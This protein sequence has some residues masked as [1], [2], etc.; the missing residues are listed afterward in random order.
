MAKRLLDIVFSALAI[1]I[2]SPVFLIATVGILISSEGP[3][4]YKARRVG[5]NG[6]I[7]TMY[8]FRSMLVEHPCK[9]VITGV[10]DSRVYPFGSFLRKSKIDELPQLFN[11]LAGH[12]S[13]VGP[14]PE[15]PKIVE[16]HF[17]P[18]QRETL[19]VL[20]GLTG[21]GSIF[22]YTQAKSYLDD[23]DIEA[24]YVKNLLPVRLELEAYYVRN[25]SLLYDMKI[26]FRTLFII[27]QVL[28]GKKKFNYPREYI[29]LYP[30]R[31]PPRKDG[32]NP[33]MMH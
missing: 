24:S 22:D 16:N 20:P 13:V 7:F 29:A 12:M 21:L 14:R 1:V 19:K 28:L 31:L 9:S 27:L 33:A 4:I 18:K 11:V 3:V 2:L 10:N 5:L 25:Q 8:K 26:V 32:S 15:D 6:R 17:T 23:D 30:D